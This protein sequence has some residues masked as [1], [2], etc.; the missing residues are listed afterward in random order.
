MKAMRSENYKG[1]E[2]VRIADMPQEQRDKIFETW[3]R[4]KII[5]I[6]R[7]KELLKDCILVVDYN[8][9]LKTLPARSLQ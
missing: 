6:L 4:S 7:D 9:W 1:I 8:N 3:D 5:N 2:F